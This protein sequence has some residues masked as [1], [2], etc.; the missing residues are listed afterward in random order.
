MTKPERADDDGHHCNGV[1]P[2]RGILCDRI[3]RFEL[4]LAEPSHSTQWALVR[5]I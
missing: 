4:F 2:K 3:S 5:W 1:R